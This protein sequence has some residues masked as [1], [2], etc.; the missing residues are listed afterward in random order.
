[1]LYLSPLKVADILNSRNLKIR[2]HNISEEE[3]YAQ[4]K[5]IKN[6]E[7]VILCVQITFDIVFRMSFIVIMVNRLFRPERSRVQKKCGTKEDGAENYSVCEFFK[8]R[9]ED[10]KYGMSSDDNP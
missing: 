8:F 2:T 1:M 6:W 5:T 9:S 4:G 7:E 10:G 3:M